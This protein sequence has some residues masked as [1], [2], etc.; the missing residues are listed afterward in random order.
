MLG[1]AKRSHHTPRDVPFSFITRS[2]MATYHIRSHHAPRDVPLPF[3]TPSVT[4]TYIHHTECDDYIPRHS[5][6]EE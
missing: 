5:S 3:I 1:V 4:A 2:V 6:F